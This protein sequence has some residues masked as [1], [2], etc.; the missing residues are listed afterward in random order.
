MAIDF[1]TSPIDKQTYDYGGVRYT[2][3]LT[4]SPGY[5]RVYEAGS[6]SPASIAEI[7][8]GVEATK[9]VAPDALAGSEYL[10]EIGITSDGAGSDVFNKATPIDLATA[11]TGLLVGQSATGWTLTPQAATDTDPGVVALDDTVISSSSIIAGTAN[12]VKTANDAAEAAVQGLITHNSGAGKASSYLWD[13]LASSLVAGNGLMV[14]HGAF[15]M[16][17]AWTGT[18]TFEDAFHGAPYAVLVSHSDV[19]NTKFCAISVTSS[20]ST[21][22]TWAGVSISAGSNV[23][24]YVHYIAIGAATASV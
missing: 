1:P 4:T 16:A 23:S 6:Q 3:D 7:N 9:F 15:S 11:G 22:F 5:W 10:T 14:C 2:F 13:S 12:A 18:H 24:G 8:A 19:T 20:T 17:S 21:T